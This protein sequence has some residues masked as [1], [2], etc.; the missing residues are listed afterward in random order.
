LAARYLAA[1]VQEITT[2]AANLP[3]HQVDTIYLGGGTP[4]IMADADIT[5]LLATCR[6]QFSVASTAE[7]TIEM[8]PSDVSL[9]KAQHYR[10]LGI[11]RVSLGV[12]SLQ[13]QEL[14]A[15][16]RDH[17][18][19]AVFSAYATLRQAGFTNISLDLIAGLPGQTWLQWEDNLHQVLQL[20]PEHLSIYLLELKPG[21]TL[22]AQV[23]QGRLAAPDEDL[24]AQMYTQLVTATAAANY[25][26]YEISNF[27]RRPSSVTSSDNLATTPTRA[28]FHPTSDNLAVTSWQAQ[29]N[30][31]YWQ[32]LPYLG[33]GVS[34]HSYYQQA[35]FANVNN[36]HG[37]IE[38][39]MATGQAVAERHCLSPLDQAREAFM[40]QL[41][42]L[43]GVNLVDFYQ[44]Y[45]IDL[46]T[47]YQDEFAQLCE[48]ELLR[49]DNQQV[50]LTARG[51]LFSNEV[52]V[53]F[54]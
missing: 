36:T 4:S 11:N 49:Y 45:Q 15:L 42:L 53:H 43:A 38:Q 7:I 25:E 22:Y 35:R 5:A 6:Q 12:Q 48:W 46:T 50:A 18:S 3:T 17:N 24:A 31:K 9:A 27:A 13:N 34:A 26:H 19:Q 41:R 51:I 29:H 32:D 2:T 37:Y 52:F 54:V 21:S 1:L 47:L 16:G 14:Q 33:F 28:A 40:L 30:K 44:R 39:V 10:D 23:K 8:N 20:A